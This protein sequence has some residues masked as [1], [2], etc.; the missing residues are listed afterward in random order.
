MFMTFC[1]LI[2]SIVRYIMVNQMFYIKVYRCKEV[3]NASL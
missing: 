1:L 2:N 3:N